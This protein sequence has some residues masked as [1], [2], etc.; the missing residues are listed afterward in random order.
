MDNLFDDSDAPWQ[1]ETDDSELFKPKPNPLLIG[2]IGI[3]ATALIVAAILA[4][5]NN[6]ALSATPYPSLIT[7]TATPSAS[8]QPK[9]TPSPEPEPKEETQQPEPP[10]PAPQPVQPAPQ[11]PQIQQPVQQQA[12]AQDLAPAGGPPAVYGV[13]CV[14]SGQTISATVSFNSGGL[15]GT[16]SANIGPVPLSTSFVAG[17]TSASLS[18]TISPH[19]QTCSVTISTAA[20]SSSGLATS[21]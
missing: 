12:P 10:A 1:Y 8:P 20:G 19:P 3:L 7:V 4:A 17:S 11:Q 13:S 21:N 9:E 18:A 2:L 16:V 5:R 15:G 14:R 6:A